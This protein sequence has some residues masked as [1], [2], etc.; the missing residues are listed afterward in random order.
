MDYTLFRGVWSDDHLIGV[1]EEWPNDC[2]MVDETTGEE[3]KRV[4]IPR[5]T[6]FPYSI[7]GESCYGSVHKDGISGS[8]YISADDFWN[9]DFSKAIAFKVR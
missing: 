2:L 9:G 1:F 7:I 3:L 8:G 4:T 5:N 6:I